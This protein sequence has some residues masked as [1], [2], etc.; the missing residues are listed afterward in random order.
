MIS[1]RHNLSPLLQRFAI[2]R[3]G[4][5]GGDTVSGFYFG[6]SKKVLIEEFWFDLVDELVVL[7][8]REETKRRDTHYGHKAK[9]CLLDQE[10]ESIF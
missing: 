3:H 1:Q 7:L 5:F 2:V 6:P 4:F 10:R 9:C 8:N